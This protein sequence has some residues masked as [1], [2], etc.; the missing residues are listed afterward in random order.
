MQ[1]KGIFRQIE[2]A[3]ECVKDAFV[4]SSGILSS[5]EF[6]IEKRSSN[7]LICGSDLAN[8]FTSMLRKNKQKYRAKKLEGGAVM[9]TYDIK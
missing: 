1:N 6:L 3:N 7:S 9:I 8:T 4:G 5:A 2:D